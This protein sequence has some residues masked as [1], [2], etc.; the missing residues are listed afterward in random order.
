MTNDCAAESCI[1][2]W[3]KNCTCNFC[4]KEWKWNWQNDTK[5][6][7]K[8][9]AQQNERVIISTDK[10]DDSHLTINEISKIG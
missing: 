10:P 5:V 7:W 1:T 8:A 9:A 2:K 3:S 4:E 6:D